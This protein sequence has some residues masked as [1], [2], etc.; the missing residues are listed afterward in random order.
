M[1]PKKDLSKK[2]LQ[3]ELKT[4]RVCFFI[5]TLLFF[6]FL[7]GV[8]YFGIYMDFY[9]NSEVPI[10]FED[11][12]NFT[13]EEKDL[14]YSIIN[15][16]KPDYLS[17]AK[18]IRIVRKIKKYGGYNQW[19][20]ITI[21]FLNNKELMKVVICHELLHNVFNRLSTEKFVEEFA[22]KGVCYN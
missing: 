21:E 19:G 10:I 18:Q 4:L 15:E 22:W 9:R 8:V 1:K 14:I 16:T 17:T 12:G 3:K 13:I 5:N 2:K 6:I 7:G 11:K 20:R